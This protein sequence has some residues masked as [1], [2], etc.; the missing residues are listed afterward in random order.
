[1]ARPR[2]TRPTDGELAIL[3]VLWD[4]GPST[5][6][7]V[8]EAL[9]ARKPPGGAAGRSGAPR[10]GAR[11]YTSV[12]KVMQIM[13]DKG[14]LRR[15]EAERSHVYRPAVPRE[16]TQRQIVGQLLDRVFGGSARTLV[17]HA[18]S[19]KPTTPEELADIRRL[20]DDFE[21]GKS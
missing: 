7:E 12:L 20:I 5:V 4:R 6:R 15:D 19:A 21:G 16:R 18:L 17:M 8:H 13:T 2:S 10:P 1:M 9:A 3:N 11:G 14:L